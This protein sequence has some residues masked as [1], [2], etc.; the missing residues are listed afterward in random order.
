M[1][2]LNDVQRE[3][4]VPKVVMQECGDTSPL[5]KRSR[6]TAFPSIFRSLH[7]CSA[8][9]VDRPFLGLCDLCFLG[10]KIRSLHGER[11]TVSRA[12]DTTGRQS[13]VECSDVFTAHEGART[14]AG[15]RS[16]ATGS[17]P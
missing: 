3:S 9:K 16:P 7:G 10:E 1:K 12:A 8:F 6:E 13:S 5:A 15:D 4:P 2:I 11:A 14:N 17:G